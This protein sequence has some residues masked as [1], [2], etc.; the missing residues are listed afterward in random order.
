MR[1]AFT[2]LGCKIN[3]FETDVL[4]RDFEL[5]GN[6]TVPFNAEADVYIINTCSVTAK[7][8]YQC[9]Q[10]IRSAVRRGRGA[11]VVVTGC[12]AELQPD[13][14]K[15]IPGVNIVY[16]NS[17]KTV[18]PG[19]LAAELF[20]AQA[21]VAYNPVADDLQAARSRTRGFL[22]VQD[23]CS[24]SCAYCIVPL[25]RG[26]SR[27]VPMSDVIREFRRL[28]RSG[29]L[30]IVLTGIH[31]GTYGADLGEGA[32]LTE[33]IRILLAERGDARIRL[34]SIEPGEVTQELIGF[35]GKG[36][37][38][39]LHI[40]LQSGD[41]TILA[42]MQRNYTSNFYKDLTAEIAERIPDIALGADVMVGFPGEGDLEF[43]NTMRLVKESPLT[44]LHVFS[45]SPRPGT[46]AADMEAQVPEKVK[47]MRSE[48]LRKLAR[49]KNQVFREMHIGA[50]ASVVVESKVDAGSGLL[51]GLTDNYIRVLISGA[52]KEHI[53]KKKYVRINHIKDQENYAEIL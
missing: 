20:P 3:Q 14:I 26:S 17:D 19:R 47:K 31:I 22:K 13:E 45:Y 12:Y 53:N 33:L 49:E 50:E 28:V 44:H 48:A 16:G 42:S 37:C 21:G 51:T 10:A 46:K 9:R 11:K 15:K 18:I 41:D 35:L 40:P 8:D 39:H 24:N 34:S 1:I 52:K 29:C 36:L 32:N 23:G 4:R 25:A 38:R 2:T 6:T 5:R 43:S 30:E 27:S 7:S